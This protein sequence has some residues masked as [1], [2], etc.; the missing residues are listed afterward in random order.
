MLYNCYTKFIYLVL[1]K[2]G[3]GST[4]DELSP[5]CV[6]SLLGIRI[7]GVA[8]GLW[9]TV[10]TSADGDVYAFGGNQFGQL[11]TGSDQAEVCPSHPTY[12]PQPH[13]YY[14]Q[15]WKHNGMIM[16]PFVQEFY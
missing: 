7:E 16:S 1:E 4:D 9:H 6:S 3:Q 11:G 15:I 5:T 13:C 10:C 8:A 14:H 2:C 12:E